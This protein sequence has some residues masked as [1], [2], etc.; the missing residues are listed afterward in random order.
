MS[1][2]EMQLLIDELH[3]L[4]VSKQMVINCQNYEI[5]ELKKEVERLEH[6]LTPKADNGEELKF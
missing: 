4:I 5:A 1:E 6:L 2:Y 3:K